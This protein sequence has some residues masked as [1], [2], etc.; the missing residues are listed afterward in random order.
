MAGVRFASSLRRLDE[1]R[2]DRC[3]QAVKEVETRKG[4]EGGDVDVASR[5]RN[6]ASRQAANAMRERCQTERPGACMRLRACVCG[7]RGGEGKKRN[8]KTR[9]MT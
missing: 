1:K 3:R 5:A 6:K 7:A 2:V 8:A 4:P 9:R